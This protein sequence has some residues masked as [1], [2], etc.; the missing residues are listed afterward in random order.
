MDLTFI[1][2]RPWNAI[3]CEDAEVNWITIVGVGEPPRISA[4]K[5]SHSQ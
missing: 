3:S 4:V 5:T 1:A 2:S